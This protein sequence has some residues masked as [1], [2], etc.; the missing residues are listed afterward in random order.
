MLFPLKC[1][2]RGQL[3]GETWHKGQTVYVRLAHGLHVVETTMQ[4][5]IKRM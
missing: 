1:P 4:E 5:G 3:K 2:F